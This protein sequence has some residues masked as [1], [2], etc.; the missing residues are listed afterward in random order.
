MC[1]WGGSDEAEEAHLSASAS[2][3][4]AKMS[5]EDS[6][7]SEMSS[8]VQS[9]WEDLVV[10]NPNRRKLEACL[11]STIMVVVVCIMGLLL[12]VVIELQPANNLKKVQRRPNVVFCDNGTCPEFAHRVL[13]W[14]NFKRTLFNKTPSEPARTLPTLTSTTMFMRNR[15]YELNTN[16]KV[17]EL[18]FTHMVG[19]FDACVHGIKNNK[20]ENQLYPFLKKTLWSVSGLQGFAG[21][22]QVSQYMNLHVALMQKFN[23]HPFGRFMRMDDN[24]VIGT[25][26]FLGT[27]QQ[28]ALAGFAREFQGAYGAFITKYKLGSADDASK[29]FDLEKDIIK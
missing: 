25:P 20:S 24:W 7:V 29:V 13:G 17:N 6:S 1:A 4:T 3:N 19:L 27:T 18:A 14:I 2:R 12:F 23:F 21:A 22:A 16:K 5:G 26:S 15:D 8:S 10:E 11:V 9:A 28:V